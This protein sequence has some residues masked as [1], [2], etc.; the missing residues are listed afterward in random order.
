MQVY[1]DFVPNATTDSKTGHRRSSCSARLRCDL[2]YASPQHLRRTWAFA[3]DCGDPY[4]PRETYCRSMT[5]NTLGRGDPST[6]MAPADPAGAARGMYP[7]CA[8]WFTALLIYLFYHLFYFFLNIFYFLNFYC[9]LV[10]HSSWRG[11]PVLSLLFSVAASIQSAVRATTHYHYRFHRIIG[12]WPCVG[13]HSFRHPGGGCKLWPA[14]Q[15]RADL[16]AA[17]FASVVILTMPRSNF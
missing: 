14:C 8:V 1:S 9:I 16:G 2:S 6:I 13:Y 17:A 11:Y 12:R 15:C 7:N 10:P 5:I 4:I 3:D